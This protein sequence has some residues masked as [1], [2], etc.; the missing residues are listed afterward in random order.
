MVL[1][2]CTACH[3]PVGLVMHNQYTLCLMV[4][5]LA[6]NSTAALPLCVV[7]VSRHQCHGCG[8]V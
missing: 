6:V 8:H 2:Q 1:V 3:L 7:G 5:R 4:W